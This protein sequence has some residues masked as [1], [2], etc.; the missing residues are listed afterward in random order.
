M[1]NLMNILKAKHHPEQY[2]AEQ[3]KKKQETAELLA[4]VDGV[5]AEH[6]RKKAEEEQ[7]TED[8]I[9]FKSD[10]SSPT[11]FIPTEK[12]HQELK[13]SIKKLFHR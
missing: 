6:N 8:K 12:G 1:S 5:L 7:D 3:A 13:E 9:L 10:P 11:S 2:A 4:F